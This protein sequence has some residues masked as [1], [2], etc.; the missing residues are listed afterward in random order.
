MTKTF[1]KFV[2]KI[3]SE[4]RYMWYY[5]QKNLPYKIHSAQEIKSSKTNPIAETQ[6]KAVL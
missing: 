2:D 1:S 3:T 6:P 4:I 5:C